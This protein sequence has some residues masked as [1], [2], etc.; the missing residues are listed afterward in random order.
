[1]R[2]L[3]RFSGADLRS[4]YAVQYACK[5]LKS[6]S[7]PVRAPTF[8][9]QSAHIPGTHFCCRLS[10][11]QQG[12]SAA[13][14]IRSSKEIQW[15]H[16]EL[17]ERHSGSQHGASTHYARRAP[18]ISNLGEGMPRPKRETNDN[19]VAQ[20]DSRPT[21]IVNCRPDGHRNVGRP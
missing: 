6:K 10:R 5:C 15:R 11:P 16:R 9:R 18:E 13:G 19:H 2:F 21:R 12:H 8:P 14:G 3:S 1:M 7:V 17:N 20:M 4:L